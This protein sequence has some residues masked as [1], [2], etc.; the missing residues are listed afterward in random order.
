MKKVL[1]ILG[2]LGLLTIGGCVVLPVLLVGGAASAVNEAVQEAENERLE[3]IDNLL[4]EPEISNLSPTGELAEIYKLN[5]E[6]TDLAREAKTEEIT[7]EIV[8]WTLPVFDISKTSDDSVRIQF[9]GDSKILGV[10]EQRP[11]VFADV[12]PQDEDENKYLIQLKEGDSATIR[13][14]IKG[15]T[16]L[17][18]AIEIDPAIIINK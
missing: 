8:E 18:R 11:T 17:I 6:I 4:N 16:P 10:G 9:A 14:Y 15:E 7:G 13:G 1:I 3:A 5:S 2:I 12:Y